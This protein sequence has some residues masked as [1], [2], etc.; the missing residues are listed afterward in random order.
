MKD[1]NFQQKIKRQVERAESLPQTKPLKKSRLDRSSPSPTPI[2]NSM[3]T[4][5]PLVRSFKTQEREDIDY[6]VVRFLCANGIP[7][8]VL[9]SPYW[10]EMVSAIST[11]PGYKAPS[12]EKTRTVLL[13]NEKERVRRSLD[14]FTEKWPTNGLSIVSDGW[15]NVKNKPLINILASNA[16]GSMFLYAHDF[17]SVEK[18]G[19]NISDFLLAVIE[20]LVPRMSYKLLLIMQLI[21]RPRDMKSQSHSKLEL[22]KVAITR[23]ASHY[24][25]LKRLIDVR[26]A[27]RTTMVSDAWKSWTQACI[28]EKTR[29]TATNIEV[30]VMCDE[31]WSRVELVLLVTKPIYKM[32]KFTDQEGPLIGDIY[33]G[34]DSILGHIRDNLRGKDELFSIVEKIV[35]ERW[36]KMN[37]PLHCL[38]HALTPKYYDLDYLQLPAPGGG[39]R[40]PPD[41]DNDILDGV[42]EALSKITQDEAQADIVR[43]QYFTFVG[44]KERFSTA[45]AIR[46]AKNPQV[47]VLEWW[48]F[49][50]GS[51]PQLRNIAIKVLSQSV[52]T[53]SAERVWSTYS[54]IHSV[55]RNRLNS[56]RADS[57]VYIHSN[58]RL[59]FLIHIRS[60]KD[61]PYKKWDINPELPVVDESVV[62]LE[63]LRW[64]NLEDGEEEPRPKNLIALQDSGDL[65]SFRPPSS[66][67]MDGL[68]FQNSCRIESA[69]GNRLPARVQPPAYSG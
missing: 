3:S 48:Q 33:E 37:I 11:M 27:L 45:A 69:K 66:G 2:H 62:R 15:T 51:T 67:T 39:K 46:D 24:I 54:Y 44:K 20:M 43:K 31:F 32:I 65:Q 35:T 28:D 49:H 53:S 60:Y 16:F 58:L 63:E 42:L 10:D 56:T 12:Y 26:E 17:S 22:L 21:A 7:F 29:D 4:R 19:K 14:P 40:I 1:R 13:D 50:G 23:F 38:A 61:G 47:D 64:K 59:L 34:M 55:K 8:N 18:S 57:L 6:E 52:S 68:R 36:E 5:S 9:R 41:Q 30:D 25:T